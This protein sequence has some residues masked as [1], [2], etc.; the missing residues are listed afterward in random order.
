M[1]GLVSPSGE[2]NMPAKTDVKLSTISY[3]ILYVKDTAKAVPFYRDVLGM[4]VRAEEPGWV[5]IDT[6]ST[7]LALH[8]E[9]KPPAERS[10]CG[11]VVFGVDDVQAA[12]ESL[13]EKGVK[14]RGAPQ[15][16]CEAGDKVGKGAD[17][18]DPDGNPLSIFGMV[19]R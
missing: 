1:H 6:G 19:P 13:K 10:G 4:K 16:V 15:I 14:F 7:V 17:F 2:Q 8:S 12:Y 9:E 11:V 18:T 3:V 5:E